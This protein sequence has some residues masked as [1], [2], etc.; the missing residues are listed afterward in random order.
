M[1]EYFDAG[2]ALVLDANAVAGLLQEI[3]AAEMT[4]SPAECAHCGRQGEV[5][6]LLAFLHG[7]GVVLRCPACENVVLRVARAPGQVYLDARGAAYL[8]IPLAAT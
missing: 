5:G 1:D 8:C 6:S 4:A 2:R 7:P 3:F